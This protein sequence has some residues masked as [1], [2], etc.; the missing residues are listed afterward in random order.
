MYYL[1]NSWGGGHRKRISIV[2]AILILTL[3][4]CSH[5]K[6]VSFDKRHNT[7]T[8]QGGKWASDEDYKKAADEYCHQPATL[9][10]MNE[11]TVGTYTNTNAQFYGRS[12]NAQATS[13]GIARYNKTFTCS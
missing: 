3:S 9:L 6:V 11:T 2:L 13:M 12:A 4:G 5:I 10:A 8:I 1:R 7:V